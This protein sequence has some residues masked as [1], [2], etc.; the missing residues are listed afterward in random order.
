MPCFRQAERLRAEDEYGNTALLLAITFEYPNVAALLLQYKETDPLHKNARGYTALSLAARS[1]RPFV[2]SCVLNRLL[3]VERLAKGELVTFPILAQ[4]IRTA[5]RGGH[6]VSESFAR[7]TLIDLYTELGL[8]ELALC[9]VAAFKRHPATCLYDCVEMAAAV[10]LRSRFV[11]GYDS[12]RSDELEAASARLQLAAAG[13]LVSLGR[14]KDGLGRFEVEQLLQ[15][16]RGEAAIKLAI[17]HSCKQFLSQPP[18]QARR[19]R[20]PHTV[21]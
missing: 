14:L 12:F 2:I 7:H 8:D 1:K 11:R 10:Q 21:T 17:R 5:G 3:G 6:A 4:V 18:V 9:V 15:S 20:E 19:R 16:P 13:C